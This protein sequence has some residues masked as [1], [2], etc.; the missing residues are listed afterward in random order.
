MIQK[1]A[2]NKSRIPE[3]IIMTNALLLF[4]FFDKEPEYLVNK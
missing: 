1:T 2:K 4:F 3:M